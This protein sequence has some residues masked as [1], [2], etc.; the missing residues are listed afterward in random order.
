[1]KENACLLWS[2][3][4]YEHILPKTIDDVRLPS[5][6]MQIGILCGPYILKCNME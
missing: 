3:T 5:D 1:M 4:Q 6:Y 2:W